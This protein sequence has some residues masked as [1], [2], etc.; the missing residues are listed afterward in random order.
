MIFAV[1]INMNPISIKIINSESNSVL[2]YHQFQRR[3]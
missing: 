2:L 1:L 3:C